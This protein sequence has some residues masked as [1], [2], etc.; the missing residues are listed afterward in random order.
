MS[1]Q[2][3]IDLRSD[4]VTRPTDEMRQ[5][6]ACAEVGDDVYGEDPT[7]E[8]LQRRAAE[9]FEREAALFV[10]SGSMGNQIAIRLHTCPGQEV[11][12]DHRSHTYNYELAA[13]SAISGVLPRPVSSEWGYL[14]WAEIEP[15]IAPKIY[16]RAQT[17]LL[18]LENTHNMAGGI[19]YPP[20]VFEDTCDRAHEAGLRVHLD[21]ARI[22]NAS[23]ELGIDVAHLTRSCDSVM[24]CL[25]KGLGAP[26]GSMLLGD[27][28]FV[29]R[30]RIIRKMLG[31][32][33]RQAGILAAA[34]LVALETMPGRLRMD[35]ENARW[36]A[37][38][39][40]E[41]PGLKINPQKV[42]TN[43]FMIDVSSTPLTAFQ[44]AVGLKEKSVWISPFDKATLRAVTHRDVSAE[45]MAQA[46]KAF[47]QIAEA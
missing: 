11:I 30:A 34:G 25:S 37:G 22:F 24:F 32:G 7:V 31:G 21:G 40:A 41:I 5:A 47:R 12:T 44:W 29:E 14:S 2:G 19:V 3:I 42:Q 4:T 20:K 10:P 27:A 23:A 28:S 6:M 26:V 43:I 8:K 35:H 18:V 1:Y 46:V 9:L 15:A 13:M 45:D 33:M 36:M 16:Y 38:R 39:L 17:A